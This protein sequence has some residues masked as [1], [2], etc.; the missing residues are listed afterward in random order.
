MPTKLMTPAQVAEHLQV[1]EH[2][3]YDWLRK[4]RLHGVKV[5]RLWRVPEPNVDAFVLGNDRDVDDEPLTAEEAAT[6]EAAWRAY[7]SGED[8][9]EPLDNVRREL[10]GTRRA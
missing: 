4:G 9:G 6:S 5:G 2:T 10:V 1:T 8:P 3:V 7:L